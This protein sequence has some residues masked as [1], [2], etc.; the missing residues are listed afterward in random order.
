M[1]YVYLT[2]PWKRIGFLRGLLTL[3]ATKRK[4]T[5]STVIVYVWG[6]SGGVPLFLIKQHTFYYHA[7][8]TESIWVCYERKF[9]SNIDISTPR[10]DTSTEI[11]LRR[12][13]QTN[14]ENST[15]PRKVYFGEELKNMS[16][17]KPKEIK[18]QGTITSIHFHKNNS[19][20]LNQKF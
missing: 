16:L 15:G 6:G 3:I 5:Y 18:I 13:D 1:A 11:L 12:N 2:A 14:E 9:Y 10:S 20:N 17:F 8:Y 7:S 19:I 4:Q